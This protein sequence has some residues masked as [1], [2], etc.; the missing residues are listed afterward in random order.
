[1]TCRLEIVTVVL[2]TMACVHKVCHVQDDGIARASKS[3]LVKMDLWD[4]VSR[5]WVTVQFRA[6]LFSESANMTALCKGMLKYDPD[7]TE[8]IAFPL[9]ARNAHSPGKAADV[10]LSFDITAYTDKPFDPPKLG[11]NVLS[12]LSLG[13]HMCEGDFSCTDER[14][15]VLILHPVYPVFQVRNV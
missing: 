9:A 14:N 5:T 6:I 13:V 11:G 12:A 4:G 15:A 10:K 2:F 7:L 8:G 1:M 3:A